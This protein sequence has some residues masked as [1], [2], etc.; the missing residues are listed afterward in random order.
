VSDDPP[1][2]LRDAARFFVD[3][4]RWEQAESVY[5]SIL[6]ID[7]QDAGARCM[8]G[9]CQMR[10]GNVAEAY[11]TIEDAVAA[12]PND[13][14]V[15]YYRCAFALERAWPLRIPPPPLRT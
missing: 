3:R 12:A 1:T 5:R 10:R 9:F 7:P 15:H 8:V 14:I 11:R 4:Q 13:W 6:Q 2:Q